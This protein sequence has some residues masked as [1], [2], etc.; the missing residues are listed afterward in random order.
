MNCTLKGLW[1]DLFQ[2]SIVCVKVR[3]TSVRIRVEPLQLKPPCL[4]QPA[5]T[6]GTY[7][8]SHHVGHWAVSPLM[9]NRYNNLNL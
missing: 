1:K 2:G 8:S 7:P 9:S 5:I 6:S 3:D 4:V